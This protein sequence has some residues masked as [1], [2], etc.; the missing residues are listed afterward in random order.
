M[1][2]LNTGNVSLSVMVEGVRAYS[3]GARRMPLKMPGI[4]LPS[5]AGAPTQYP[6]WERASIT[7]LVQGSMIL[8]GS[9]RH[10]G[11]PFASP[12]P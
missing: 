7:R 9:S 4:V 3:T 8:S 5:G 12:R 11:F 10:E 6:S 1:V 2:I